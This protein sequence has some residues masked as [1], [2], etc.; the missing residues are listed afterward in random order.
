MGAYYN[1]PAKTYGFI[2][3]SLFFNHFFAKAGLFWL[4]GI[5]KK[6]AINEWSVLRKKPLYLFLFGL[7]AFALLGM[8]PFAGFWGK[9]ALVMALATHGQFTWIAFLLLGSLLEAVYLLRWFGIALKG[10]YKDAAPQ[11]Q[12]FQKIALWSFAGFTVFSALWA[13][14]L[15]LQTPFLFYLPLIAAFILLLLSR[16][17]VKLQ[18][19]LALSAIAVYTYLILPGL[20]GMAFYFDLI[21][22]I[23]GWVLLLAS[24]ARKEEGSIGFYPAVVLMLGALSNLT[25]ATDLIQ[26]FFSWELMTISSYLLI[27]H[28]KKSQ[29]A[30]LQYILFSLGGA[31]FMLLGI[32]IAHSVSPSGWHMVILGA[33]AQTSMAIW[34]FIFIALGLL[35][36]V[37]ALGLHIWAPGA[38]SEADD[39]ATPLIS[40]ILSKAGV[41][42]FILLFSYM[43]SPNFL[44]VVSISSV[45]G[46]I[47]VLTAFFATLYAVFQEDA[48]KMLAYSSIGQVGY[49]ILGLALMS[50]LGWAAALWHTF[51]HMLFKGLLFLAIAGVIY[52]TGTRNMFEMGGL[53][54]RMPYSFVSVLIGIIALSGIPPLT[55]FGG[56]WL[57]YEA[58]I[59][60]GWYLQTGLAL[61]A[62]TIA[63]LYCF[64]LIHAIFLGQPKPNQLKIKEAPF[65]ILLPQY[66]LI[67]AIMAFSVKPEW[68]LQPISAMINPVFA[69]TLHWQGS[70]VISSLGY[71][72]GTAMMI[73]VMVLFIFIL[74][75]ALR[76][77]PKPQKVKSFNIVFAAER[78]HRPETTHY[79]YMF[80]APYKRALQP[81]LH[82]MARPFWNGVSEWF[83]TVAGVVRQLYSG[84]AQTNVLYIFIFAII[85]YAFS[86]GV[87]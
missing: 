71:W 65:W 4:A 53:I 57:L 68:L 16:L 30:G 79:A 60:K 10:E 17:P 78:P 42:G 73:I 5:V 26:F 11:P 32:A 7:F 75:N 1:F 24:L 69:S 52:R 31:Y 70:T 56:K 83:N 20:R 13:S 12:I 14:S 67:A 33:A 87:F 39:D 18:G 46:W 48:K 80:F 36:K 63:F 38:Y 64:R 25:L 40:G 84:N 27:L 35:V 45:I 82:P 43:G 2:L 44:P 34:I 23:G 81:V 28:G 55:G 85:L 66:I 58:L 15:L 29:K 49:I 77:G 47:G 37:A 59:E 61:F 76:M 74:L 54:K 51:N 41:F 21:F 50:H 19:G 3:I 9:W 72:N 6:E 8:P 22:L 62:S 86:T